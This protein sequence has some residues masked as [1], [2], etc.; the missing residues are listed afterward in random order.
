MIPK[1][2]HYC[3][4]G[5][6]EKPKI[7]QKCIET[8]SKMEGYEIKEWN[9]ENCDFSENKYLYE[10]YQQQKWAFVSD[11]IRLKV[12]YLYGGIYLDTDVEIC[13]IFPDE[14][15]NNEFFISFMFNCNLS[16]AI[17]GAEKKNDVI[18]SLLELYSD[19]KVQDSPNNDMFTRYFLSNYDEF[20]LNNKYQ[21]IGD[22][23]TIYPKEVFE[24]P[25]FKKEMGY[26]IHHF[27][28]SWRQEKSYFKKF[29]IRLC[30][31]Y[32]YQ[33]IVRKRAIRK[34]PFYNIYLSHN[35]K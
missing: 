3:W 19:K 8:W 22:G 13:K 31:T 14:F 18:K 25:S 9:E 15:L 30:P 4:F 34:S 33:H 17:I 35:K 1:V 24:C 27:T 26:S 2:I 11:Y 12:L 20:K 29:I 5:K 16:T 23:V 7:I 10:A 6:K 21:K 32:L 28:G